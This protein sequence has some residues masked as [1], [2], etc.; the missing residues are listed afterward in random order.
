[1]ARRSVLR[2]SDSD[3]EQIAERLRKATAEG[4]LMAEELEERV[5]TALRA[6][7]Y[8]ELDAL[9]ADLPREPLKRQRRAPGVVAIALAAVLVLAVLAAVALLVTGLLTAWVVWLAVGWWCFGR[10]HYRWQHRR[11]MYRSW[12]G[13]GRGLYRA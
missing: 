1:M 7:T 9:V 2:A 10:R 5:G 11:R 4:R 6:R 8:G 3:R 12:Q 13:S